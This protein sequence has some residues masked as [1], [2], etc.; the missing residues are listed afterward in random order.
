MLKIKIERVGGLVALTV[1]DNDQIVTSLGV[2][3]SVF[4]FEQ[5]GEVSVVNVIGKKLEEEKQ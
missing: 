3:S 5:I 1:L 4:K 2:E